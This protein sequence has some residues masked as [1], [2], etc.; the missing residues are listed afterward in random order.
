MREFILHYFLA[1]D[2]IEVKEVIPENAGRDSLPMFLN[3]G[4]IPKVSQG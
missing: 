1:D 2:E 4:K 3:K